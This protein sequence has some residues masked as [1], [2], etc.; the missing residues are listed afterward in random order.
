MSILKRTTALTA[1]LIISGF[2]LGVIATA[3]WDALFRAGKV[4]VSTSG[5]QER[6]SPRNGIMLPNFADIAEEIMPTVVTVYSEQVIRIRRPSF[7]FDDEFFRRFF[8]LPD[9]P[10]DREPQYDEFR[11]QGLGSGVIVT[12]D[13]YILTNNHVIANA[14]DIRVK[15]GD[16]TFDAEVVGTDIKTDLAVLK[17]EPDGPLSAI[18]L[19]DSDKIRIGEWVLAV[20]HPFNLDH[21]V[22]AGILSAKGRNRVGITDYEDFLQTDAAINPGNS[23]GALV[24]M[25]GELIGINTAIAT[26]TGSSAGVGF[27]IPSNMAK[28]VMD[29]LIEHGK[30]RRG[31]VGINIQDLTPELADAM[32]IDRTDG[33]IITH[34]VSGQAGDKAGLKASDLVISIDG[35]PVKT[36]SELRNVIAS[37]P[38]G[39]KISLE[40]I[41]DGR[42]R[43]IDIVLGD[44]PDAVAELKPEPEKSPDIGIELEPAE[45]SDLVQFGYSKGLIVKSVEPGSPADRAGIMPGDIVFEV[46][47][48][49]V[50]KIDEFNRQLQKTP[51]GR[52]LLLLV[53]R[54]DGMMYVALNLHDDKR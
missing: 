29:Q 42:V 32:G 23:G 50:G 44:S 25:N 11:Q 3:N 34:V 40:I 18:K 20:G 15:A 35:R 16:R 54:G 17:I 43:T 27:A 31:Y 51:S 19:G 26:R 5:A 13:G 37:N 8:G 30:V 9:S 39:T 33:V 21:T 36:S 14:D 45:P 41:R 48:S 49:E 7:G 24:N 52:P 28:A 4:E 2:L 22:T 6:P 38:P 1:T 10:R 53:G 46:N 47:R 12:T